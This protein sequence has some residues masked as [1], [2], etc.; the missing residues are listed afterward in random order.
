MRKE[1]EK[2]AQKIRCEGLKSKHGTGLFPQGWQR[3]SGWPLNAS[4]YFNLLYQ[5]AKKKEVQNP[6][7]RA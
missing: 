7:K 2:L 1:G 5:T 3:N 6:E 4:F